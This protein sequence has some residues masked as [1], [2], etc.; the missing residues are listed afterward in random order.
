MSEN[1]K[2]VYKNGVASYY[3]KSIADL[4][5]TIVYVFRVL[6]IKNGWTE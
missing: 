6:G 5:N 1:I 2:T 3:N 4:G